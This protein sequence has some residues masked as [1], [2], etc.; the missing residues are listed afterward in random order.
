MYYTFILIL[1]NFFSLKI[2]KSHPPFLFLK[3][4]QNPT[5]KP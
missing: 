2:K 4:F 3:K 5:L 1:Y